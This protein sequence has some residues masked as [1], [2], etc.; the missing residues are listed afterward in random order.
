MSTAYSLEIGRSIL[1][2][3]P[4]SFETVLVFAQKS[5]FCYPEDWRT[6]F[7]QKKVPANFP[8]YPEIVFSA[9]WKGWKHFFDITWLQF[10]HARAIVMNELIPA[11]IDTSTK[12]KQLARECKLPRGM[13]KKPDEFYKVEWRGWGFWFGKGE[14]VKWLSFNDART[15]T[16][17]TLVPLGI[18]TS[19]KY[20][21][22]AKEGKLPPGMPHKPADHFK[23]EWQGWGFWLGKED[24]RSPTRSILAFHEAMAYVQD[25]L[26]PLGIDT[27][28]KYFRYVSPPQCLPNDIAKYYKHR[29]WINSSH[30]F[31]TNKQAVCKKKD[32]A[33]YAEVKA[34]CCENL[35]PR[36]ITGQRKFR[37][38]LR[39]RYENA[40]SWPA[41]FPRGVENFYT[42]RKEWVS[43]RDLFGI[44]G[45]VAKESELSEHRSLAECPQRYFGLDTSS[46]SDGN[47]LE[48]ESAVN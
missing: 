20:E 45:E 36:G 17:T 21:Q 15:V 26:C 27:L 41:N 35:T 16:L 9:Q 19:I 30:F 42:R 13:P 23:H 46:S 33:S 6:A 38:Y 5:G 39:G 28:D 44:T 48:V 7:E 4:P 10:D 40:P 11:G 8:R 22:Y 25:F 18:D 2:D 1:K 43:Y 29:G 3:N 12:Y 34:W 37:K 14:P 31:G 47:V 24:P 32:C